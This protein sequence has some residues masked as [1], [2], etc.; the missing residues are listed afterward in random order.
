MCAAI[1]WSPRVCGSLD[2]LRRRAAH[3]GGH[4]QTLS[5]GYLRVNRDGTEA[6]IRRARQSGVGR[7]LFASTVAVKFHDQFRYYYAQSKQ[8]AE[9]VVIASG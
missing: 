9:A 1:F 2:R 7:F 8:D 5:R 6:L 3:G 4:R